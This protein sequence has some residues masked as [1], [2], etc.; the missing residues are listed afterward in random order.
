MENAEI[1]WAG[2]R[3]RFTGRPLVM[4]VV[5]VTP[6]SFSDG[7]A[8]FNTTAAV[9]HGLKLADEGA[10]ML[11]IGGESSRPFSEPVPAEEETR[12]VIP[13]LEALAQKV[14]IPLSIDTTKACVARRAIAVGASMVNDISALRMD[15][16]M[17]HVLRESDVPVILM[18]ML[19]TPKTMQIDPAY[20]DL[21]EEI[22][23]FFEAAIQGAV[24]AGIARNRIL[25]D[26]G[27]GFGK[28][29][30]HNLLL[31]QRLHRFASLGCPI[32][33]GPSRKA[34]IRRLLKSPGE[35]EPAPDSPLVE[36]GTQAA[37]AAAALAGAHILRVHRVAE[38][39]AT[40]TI[41]DA[42]QRARDG[43]SDG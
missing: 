15:D 40:L 18:H 6:D 12:R 33:L 17:V 10:D 3:L 14:S 23:S 8:F 41:I 38:T 29:A 1:C 9:E 42:I 24:T 25:I 37:V 2:H 30:A 32:V 7:G 35:R 31:I 28:T 5:N 43:I 19:G 11:D 22:R 16:E 4:G 27:I 20:R 21:V 26:P 39:R 36:T 34:F 13:V